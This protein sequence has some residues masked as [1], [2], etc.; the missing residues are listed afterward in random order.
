LLLTCVDKFGEIKV[1]RLSRAI[2]ID[3]L[4]KKLRL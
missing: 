2:G 1:K 4:G 3:I